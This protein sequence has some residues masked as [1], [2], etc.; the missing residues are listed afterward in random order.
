MQYTSVRSQLSSYIDFPSSV[1]NSH[2][3]TYIASEYS[4]YERLINSIHSP[5]PCSSCSVLLKEKKLAKEVIIYD[6]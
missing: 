5:A 1:R 3:R 2:V 4:Y 6:R